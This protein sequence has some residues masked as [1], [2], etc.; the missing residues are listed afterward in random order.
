MRELTINQD[1]DGVVV[2]FEAEMKRLTEGYEGRTLPP[3]TDWHI[4]SAWEMDSSQWYE[5]FERSVMDGVFRTAKPYPG[6]IDAL[7]RLLDSQHR[8]RFVTSKILHSPA[9]TYKAMSDCLAWLDEYDLLRN[10]VE[11]CFTHNKQGYKADVVIDDKPDLSWV[12]AGAVNILYSQPWNKDV[13]EFNLRDGGSVVRAHGWDHVE[14]IIED[15]TT[16]EG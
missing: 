7:N 11:V 5:Y 4:H 14:A 3:W 16:L 2:Q 13:E 6:A 1:L 9:A 10:E 12:Q 8:L 15:L